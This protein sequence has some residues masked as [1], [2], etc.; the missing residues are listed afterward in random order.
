VYFR[1]VDAAGTPPAYAV[2]DDDLVGLL[3]AHDE[4]AQAA[5][6]ALYD[7]YA[8][9]VYG[10]A[11]RMVGDAGVA[12]DLLQETFW[13]LWQR[14][15]QYQPGRVRFATWL[16]RIAT[17]LGTSELRR[18]RCRPF[19]SFTGSRVGRPAPL[20]PTGGADGPPPDEPVDLTAD[21]PEEVWLADQRRRVRAAL[22]GLPPEQ[23]QAVELAYFEGL[24]HA[25]IAATQR[26]PL[27]TVKTRLALGLRKLSVLLAHEGLVP[28]AAGV[29]PGHN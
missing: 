9:A 20:R 5:L 13:R 3:P 27:S 11:R 25:Q 21:V 16:L 6:A 7:R 22:G 29:D 19:D 24:T 8:G 2:R 12:E 28:T 17:N 10:L 18:A 15:D 14:A 23:R 26:A 1:E 4:G